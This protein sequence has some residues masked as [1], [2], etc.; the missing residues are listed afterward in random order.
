MFSVITF[1]VIWLTNACQIVSTHS[2][3][4]RTTTVKGPRNIEAMMA[5]A[6]I[7]DGTFVGVYGGNMHD[8]IRRMQSLAAD[9][10]M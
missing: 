1:T 4:F 9:M 7:I 3:S 10:Y 6:T 5:A 2:S 8:I